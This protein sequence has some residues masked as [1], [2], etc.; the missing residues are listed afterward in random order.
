M[1]LRNLRKSYC[2]IICN[3]VDHLVEVDLFF[4]KQK[5]AYEM[6]ISDWSSDVCSSDLSLGGVE[7]L[8]PCRRRCVATC[9]AG[10]GA[11]CTAGSR[12]PGGLLTARGSSAKAEGI[13]HPVGGSPFGGARHAS[14]TGDDRRSSC[15]FLAHLSSTRSLPEERLEGN[16]W[17]RRGRA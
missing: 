1:L 15:R 16:K 4:F 3:L 17:H 8:R 10:V 7:F 14:D 6:R 9:G 12:G 11:R 13:V 2:S 5:T